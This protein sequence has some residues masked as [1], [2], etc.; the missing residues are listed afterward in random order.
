MGFYLIMED[1][2]T[3]L[4]SFVETA[5]RLVQSGR[6]DITHWQQVTNII[7][8]QMVDAIEFIHSLNVVHMDISLEN[9]LINEVAVNIVENGNSQKVRFHLKDIQVKLCD[10]GL[11][12][13]YTNN[14]CLSSK[15]CGKDGYK[16]P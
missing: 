12:Q 16:S 9:W 8:K 2:G 10:F 15:Y 4:F 7:F 11:A 1:G 5:H 3:S 13:L 14:Q 6:I